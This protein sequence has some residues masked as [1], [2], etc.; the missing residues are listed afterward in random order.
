MKV[1]KSPEGEWMFD[2]G[3]HLVAMSCHHRKKGA[4]GGCYA[5]ALRTLDALAEAGNPE[6]QAVISACRSEKEA[7]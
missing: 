6:A 2:A 3:P 7:A 1:V 4:C 5:R